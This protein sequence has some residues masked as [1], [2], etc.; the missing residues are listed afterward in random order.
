M[1]DAVGPERRPPR[2]VGDPGQT[3]AVARQEIA[4]LCGSDTNMESAQ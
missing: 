1:A 3:V 2:K 4:A